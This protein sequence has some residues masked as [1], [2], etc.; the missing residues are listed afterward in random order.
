M[1]WKSDHKLKGGT[2]TICKVLSERHLSVTY[3]AKTRKG[4]WVVIKTLSDEA[5]KRSD[6]SRLQAVFENEATKLAKNQHPHIVR[7][8]EQFREDGIPCISMEY[9]AGSTLSE[10]S[11]RILPEAEAVKYIL[12]IGSA[13]S[14]LHKDRFYHRDIKPD[15]I[16]LRA[17]KS[18]AVLIDFGLVRQFDQDL[19]ETRRFDDITPGY[20]APEL[21]SKRGIRGAYTDIYSLGAT[22]YTLVTGEIP[23][24]AEDRK[25]FGQKIMFPINISS[26]IQKAICWAMELDPTDRPQSI[27]EW[28]ELLEYGRENRRRS[29]S[30]KG[31]KFNLRSAEIIAAIAAAGALLAGLADWFQIFQPPSNPSNSAPLQSPSPSPTPLSSP[32][33]SP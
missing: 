21:Y 30:R 18:E 27:E 4:D 23:P 17:G 9:V 29:T 5:I 33:Q 8:E 20:T 28:L 3:L 26:R 6:S 24:N 11:P 12:Q 31:L 13:L 15:N 7:L 14:I 2:Y 19:T 16:I 1:V 10:H 32:I 22:L 25:A